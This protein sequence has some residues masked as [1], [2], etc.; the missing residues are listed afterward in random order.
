M[1]RHNF[2]SALATL[3]LITASL[4]VE[5]PARATAVRFYC[6]TANGTPATL[7]QTGN[8]RTV[9][10]IR[11]VS[12]RFREAGWT[13]ERRCQEVSSRF[14][15][16]RR[17][18]RLA[19]LTTGRMNGL[20]VICTARANAGPCDGLLYTLKPGQDAT[21]TLRGLLAVRVNSRGPL[22]ETSDRLYVSVQ[23]LLESA[24]AL[25][26]TPESA[27]AAQPDGLW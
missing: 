16:F 10:V 12:S 1:A 21:A 26:N 2:L 4:T 13:P 18:G 6:G 22:N 25:G 27:A 14:E 8:G 7:A 17:Q 23:E 19:Y 24:T 5:A 9:S 3:G 11:W 15:E 20:P